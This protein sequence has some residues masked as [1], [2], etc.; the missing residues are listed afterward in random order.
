[1]KI[2]ERV[3]CKAYLEKKSDGV[4]LHCTEHIETDYGIGK[5]IEDNPATGWRWDED[6]DIRVV[7]IQTVYEN[8]RWTTKT[9][10]D[11][12]DFDGNCVEKTYRQRV[13]KEFDGFLVGVT[14][15]VTTGLIG[16]NSS[17]EC[18]NGDVNTFIHLFKEHHYEKVGVVYFK[19]NCKRYVLM[20]DMEIIE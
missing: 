1:M 9:L 10:K 2:F 5:R 14:Q 19:N 18:E 17:D 13:E 16:T 3:H 20:E 8:G 7:A 6:Q 11:L 15:I 12:S 4:A